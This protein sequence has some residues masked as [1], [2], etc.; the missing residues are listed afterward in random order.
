MELLHDLVKKVN[1]AQLAFSLT[2]L[3]AFY[4]NLSIE[5]RSK[6]KGGLCYEINLLHV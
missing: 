2:P 5:L 4:V 3:V 6:D 1:I